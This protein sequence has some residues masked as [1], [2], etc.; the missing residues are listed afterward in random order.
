MDS[1]SSCN[2]YI[3]L[4]DNSPLESAS[5]DICPFVASC[6]ALNVRDTCLLLL[7]HRRSIDNYIAR[8]DLLAGRTD[9]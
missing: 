6:L 1:E 9:N 5:L 7:Q 2:L 4:R 3:D 8:Q